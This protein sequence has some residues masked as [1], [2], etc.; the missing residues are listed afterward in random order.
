[1][2]SAMESSLPEDAFVL[3]VDEHTAVILDPAAGTATVAGNGVM[4]VRRQGQST[5]YP[6]GAIV[7]FEEMAAAGG[8]GRPG[9][10]GAIPPTE[11]AEPEEPADPAEPSVP[12]LSL[13]QATV[14][15]AKRFEA[16]MARRDVDGGA[17][18]IL[19]LEQ[20]LLDWSADTLT[21]D[22]GT[23]A[24]GRLRSMV[25]A[26]GELAK[27]GARDPREVVGPFI[28]ALLEVRDQARRARDFATSDR[29]RDR[30]TAAG[31]EVRDT[32]TGTE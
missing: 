6:P 32:P 1:R 23:F 22:E 9:A 25:V 16:A 3:G 17:E 11:V 26:M 21:S 7:D 27:V 29:I 4:T 18:A 15:I 30:L 5:T 2:L 19:A 8:S 14:Q 20:V 24:R 28:E 13:R 10:A 31:V 12:A